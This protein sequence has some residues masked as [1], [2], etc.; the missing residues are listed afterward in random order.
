MRRQALYD[1]SQKIIDN[2]VDTGV[3]GFLRDVVEKFRTGNKENGLFN[4]KLEVFQKYM[5]AVHTY[6]DEEI[7]ICNLL[8]LNELNEVSWWDSLTD[9]CNPS[10]FFEMNQNINFCINHLPKLLNLIKQDYIQDIKSNNLKDIPEELKGKSI[11]NVLIV[12]NESQFS[13]PLRLTKTLE[14]IN[15]LYSVCA[16]IE[17]ENENDLIVLACDSGSDKSFDFLGLAKVTEQVKDIIFSIWDKRVFHRQKHVSESLSLITEALPILEKINNMKENNSLS[18]EEAEILKRQVI[19]GSTQF[20][21]AGVT[22][23]ELN[24]ISSHN[25]KQLLMPEPKL[26]VSPWNK[27]SNNN[28]IKIEKDSLKLS[29]EEK[30]LL[31]E[32]KKKKK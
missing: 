21:E 4:N 30:K 8:K 19:L 3:K 6:T 12:E 25:P 9:D 20:I 24:E 1:S 7:Y 27:E 5:I 22:I 11:L 13:S 26:L 16:K 31:K 32:L 17:N 2:L 14:A 18:A 10:I 23:P 28:E 15:N 29:K